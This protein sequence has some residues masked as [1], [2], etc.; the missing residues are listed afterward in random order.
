MTNNL[1][2]I[3]RNII[4]N[5]NLEENIPYFLNNIVGKY[6]TYSTVQLAL[7]YFTYY[8]M[9]Y[10]DKE[11][12][13]EQLLEY[14][15][16]INKIISDT[17][18]VGKSGSELE[19]Y[20]IEVDKLRSEI[21]SKMDIIT[22]YSDLF[23]IYEY[24]LNRV[25]YRFNPMEDIEDD[26]TFARE[27][28]R[29]I[30]NSEDNVLINE[31]IKEVIGQLPI[32]ITR[33]KY[34]DYLRDGLFE[35][36]GVQ[37]AT[38]ET[39]IYLIRSSASLDI[40][41]DIKDEYPQLWEKKEVLEKLDF[42]NITK[43]EYDTAL[44]IINETALFL[45]LIS[46]AYYNLMEI[47]N[48]LYVILICSP[49]SGVESQD[50]RTQEEAGHYIISAINNSFLANE[51]EEPSEDILDK[52]HLLEGYLEEMDYKLLSYEDGISHLDTNHRA[53]VES[54]MQEKLL[55]V[56]LLSKDLL[57][58]S[59]FIDLKKKSQAVVDS[60]KIQMELD[61]L[62]E[63]LSDKLKKSDRMIMRAI[64]ANTINRLPV[65]FKNHTEVM[66]YVLYSL[67]KCSDRAEKYA[68]MEIINSMMEE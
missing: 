56:L 30:F 55:N 10:D 2:N 63:D 23:A 52:F 8:E 64:M 40:T 16:K 25:E 43:E 45:E 1:R 47:I 68:C 18:T 65:F 61:K 57:S 39:Y 14:S 17:I 13:D 38:L 33:Q 28:L 32:R 24:A 46:T 5:S 9:Y 41:D 67:N 62:T 15:K 51:L 54:L 48:E 19:E 11:L 4:K 60:K 31:T 49:Y 37:E 66:D 58:G 35:L 59:T 6:K 29:Y 22:S 3:Y 27:V 44:S 34:F 26:E 36:N 21:I 42:K 53:L 7:L 50:D 12:W 20:V